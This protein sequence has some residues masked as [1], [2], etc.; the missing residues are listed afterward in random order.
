[1]LMHIKRISSPTV[2]HW[3]ADEWYQTFS[4]CQ[5]ICAESRKDSTLIVILNFTAS[6]LFFSEKLFSISSFVGVVN[7]CP[8]FH[9]RILHA[10]RPIDLNSVLQFCGHVLLFP[11]PQAD[12]FSLPH[13]S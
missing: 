13:C 10:F 3:R 12:L 7:Q 11:L 2:A 1:M 8:D 5:G 4:L 6:C 9:S